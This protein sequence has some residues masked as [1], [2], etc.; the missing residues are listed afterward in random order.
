LTA[1]RYRLHVYVQK[2]IYQHSRPYA[3][4][5]LSAAVNQISSPCGDNWSQSRWRFEQIWTTQ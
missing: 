5:L 4:S 2:S 1:S 3:L